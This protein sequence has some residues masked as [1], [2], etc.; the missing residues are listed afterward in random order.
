MSKKDMTVNPQISISNPNPRIK[1]KFYNKC[2]FII[3]KIMTL[4]NKCNRLPTNILVVMWL[5]AH[6]MYLT[7]VL[8][9]VTQVNT[10]NV[11]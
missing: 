3:W 11:V 4:Q 5:T 10:V 9:F 2:H 7:L 6:S 1:Q 8:L